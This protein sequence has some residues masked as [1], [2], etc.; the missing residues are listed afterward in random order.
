MATIFRLGP[1]TTCRR[2]TVLISEQ[3]R[4]RDA[5][6]QRIQKHFEAKEKD[7]CELVVCIMDS[8]WNELR[9]T[10]KLN[11]TVKYGKENSFSFQM[12]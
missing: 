1:I 4:D 5:N 7:R 10:I 12:R 6:I 2:D 11:G 3:D 9:G 8:C